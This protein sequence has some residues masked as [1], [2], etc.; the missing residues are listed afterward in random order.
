MGHPWHVAILTIESK[1]YRLVTST[2]E[3]REVLGTTVVFDD[4]STFDLFTNVVQDK[5][6]GALEETVLVSPTSMFYID[7]IV[8]VNEL[9]DRT[10]LVGIMPD[11]TVVVHKLYEGAEEDMLE[12][13]TI[14]RQIGSV[15]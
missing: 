15:A 10:V 9:P 4:G 11:N 8:L 3:V 14:M 2:A 7:P 5:S 13:T 6:V 12:L 1:E